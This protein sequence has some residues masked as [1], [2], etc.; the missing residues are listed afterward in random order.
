MKDNIKALLEKE[1]K[2]GLADG[3]DENYEKYVHFVSCVHSDLVEI[4][5][6]LSESIRDNIAELNSEGT[7]DFGV[8]ESAYIKAQKIAGGA[9][10]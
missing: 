8:V 10:K 5:R 1:D 4:V 9:L 3:S 6:V 7:A 2:L